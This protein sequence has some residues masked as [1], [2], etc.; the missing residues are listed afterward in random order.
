MDIQVTLLDTLALY[1]AGIDEKLGT[2]N[3]LVRRGQAEAKLSY[4]GGPI[5]DKMAD[6]PTRLHDFITIRSDK[7]RVGKEL[8]L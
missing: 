2:L 6:M 8:R 5:V 4:S 1:V 7:S 3:S